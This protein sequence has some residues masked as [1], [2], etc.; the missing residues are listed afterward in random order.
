MYILTGF[1]VHQ[2]KSDSKHNEAGI[3]MRSA[4]D[5]NSVENFVATTPAAG[6]ADGS[7]DNN[8]EQQHQEYVNS[9]ATNGSIQQQQQPPSDGKCISKNW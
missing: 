7:V 2:S 4:N 9:S 5:T 3:L 1:S 8:I 6:I